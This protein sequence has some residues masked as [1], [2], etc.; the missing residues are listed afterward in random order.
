MA[1]SQFD[2]PTRE[3]QYGK[4]GSALQLWAMAPVALLSPSA[5]ARVDR[6][7]LTLIST[8][9]AIFFL[10]AAKTLFPGGA[11]L[12][13]R[14][15]WAIVHGATLAPE[16]ASRDAGYPLLIILSGF[17]FSHSL[18][19]LLLIQAGFAILLPL[20]IYEGLQRLSPT[21]AFYAGLTSIVMLSPFYFMKMIHHDQ[22]YIFFSTAMLC[23]LLVFVQTRRFRFLYMFA[24]FAIFASVARPAGNAL[25]PM[26]LMVSYISARGSITHYVVCLMAFVVFLAGYTWHREVIFDIAHAKATPSY[27][28]TQLF[29]NPYINML[30]YGI[31]LSPSDVG[32]NFAQV[33]TELRNRLQPNPK[34]SKFLPEHYI[35]SA[36]AQQFAE[37]NMF[38]LTTDELID[39]VLARPNYEYFTLLSEANDDHVLLAA[40]LEIARTHPIMILRYCLRNFLH[41]IFAPGY[42]HTRYTFKPFSPVGLIFFPA[43]SIVSPDF[44]QLPARAVREINF[45]SVSPRPQMIGWLLNVI[46][47][48]WAKLYRA[49]AFILACLMVAAWITVAARVAEPSRMWPSRLHLDKPDSAAA[50]L[51]ADGLV[52]SIIIASLLLIYNA[53][54]TSVLAE[55]DFRYREMVD[56][57]VVLI[58]GLGLATI[59]YWTSVASS[60]HRAAIL[61]ER[62]SH[63]VRLSRARDVWQ[64][65]TAMRLAMIV[66]GVAIAGFASWALFMLKNTWA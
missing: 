7:K 19:P 23:V 14:Y 27:T 30:D 3:T 41:F 6:T 31:K 37:A 58:A 2:L 56:L 36:D 57:P 46:Q 16:I 55:P 54:V 64:R 61:T 62:W 8:L 20:L 44:A 24:I 66:V 10:F 59:P 33:V 43:T 63:A 60:R 51:L 1:T 26:F 49:E 34:E 5:I 18:I 35:G 12:F 50:L 52:H 28:G 45:D 29:Y 48:V 25:F 42:A 21:I 15:A 65:F 32:P 40:S 11:I 22:A 9:A 4:A 13:V 17:P 39:Q 38:G 47:R 53:A